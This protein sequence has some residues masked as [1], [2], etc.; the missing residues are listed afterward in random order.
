MKDTTSKAIIFV[1]WWFYV[2]VPVACWAQEKAK[3][4]S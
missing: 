3:A 1:K 4:N 2:P